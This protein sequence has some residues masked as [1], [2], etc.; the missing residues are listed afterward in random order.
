MDAQP[1]LVSDDKPT[2]WFQTCDEAQDAFWPVVS[3][4]VLVNAVYVAMFVLSIVAL[5]YTYLTLKEAFIEFMQSTAV[6]RIGF[7]R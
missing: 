7:M 3:L 6:S 4:G 5:S 2:G 1:K